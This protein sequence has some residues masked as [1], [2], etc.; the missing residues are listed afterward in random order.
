VH[1]GP[2]DLQVD[3]RGPGEGRFGKE[4]RQWSQLQRPFADE[5]ELALAG[6]VNVAVDLERAVGGAHRERFRGHAA[7]GDLIVAGASS[8]AGSLDGHRCA[9][10]L[11]LG[12]HLRQEVRPPAT[13]ASPRRTPST[14]SRELRAQRADEGGDP[15]R[16]ASWM[17]RRLLIGDRPLVVGARFLVDGR[18]RDTDPSARSCHRPRGR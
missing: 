15:E 9:R 13:S 8:T 14:D 4:R 1:R 10:E 16:P 6:K 12:L 17:Q 11:D 2:A 18:Q 3:L 5:P 7:P